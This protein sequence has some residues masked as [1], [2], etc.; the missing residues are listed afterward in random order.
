MAGLRPPRIT[1]RMGGGGTPGHCPDPSLM[2]GPERT[3]GGAVPPPRTRARSAPKTGRIRSRSGTAG[4]CSGARARHVEVPT[5]VP[6]GDPVGHQLVTTLVTRLGTQLERRRHSVVDA[7]LLL[8]LRVPAW[9]TCQSEEVVCDS[10]TRSDDATHVYAWVTVTGSRDWV[11]YG[12]G[13]GSGDLRCLI[14]AAGCSRTV[15]TLLRCIAQGGWGGPTKKWHFLHHFVLL[16][17]PSE[18]PPPL[19][20]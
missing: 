5:G 11:H 17:C 3:V 4:G 10:Q 9:G 2:R 1:P 18:G 12:Q 20:A 6:V 19:L 13:R 14:L 8:T 15:H 7:P 16:K